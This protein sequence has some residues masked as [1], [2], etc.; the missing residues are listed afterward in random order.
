MIIGEILT[1]PLLLM[2][3]KLPMRVAINNIPE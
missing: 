1:A 2:M 3:S